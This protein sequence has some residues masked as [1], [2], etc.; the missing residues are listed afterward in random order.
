M[1][2]EIKLIDYSDFV[3]CLLQIEIDL[4]VKR[5]LWGKI[6]CFSVS[7]F[8]MNIDF[9]RKCVLVCVPSDF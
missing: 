4:D 7:I 8:P 9:P 3:F 1:K 2:I 5:R 6:I